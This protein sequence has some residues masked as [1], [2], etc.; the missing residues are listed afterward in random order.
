MYFAI[1]GARRGKIM[2]ITS[3]TVT[4]TYETVKVGYLLHKMNPDL[5]LEIPENTLFSYF[6]TYYPLRTVLF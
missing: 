1:L 5:A 3:C 2:V 6:T 4:S